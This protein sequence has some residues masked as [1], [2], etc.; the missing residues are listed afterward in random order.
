MQFDNLHITENLKLAKYT[1]FNQCGVYCIK[2]L[3]TGA[4]YIGSSVDLGSRL[5]S[6]ILNYRSNIH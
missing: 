5:A 4:M 3:E 6:H 2:C 1:L